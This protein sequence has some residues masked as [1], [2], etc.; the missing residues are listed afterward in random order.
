[1]INKSYNKIPVIDLFAGPGGLA[2]GFSSFRPE[3]GRPFKI[4]LSI[5]KDIH[6]YRTLELRSFFRQFPD[7]QV[8]N[9]YYSYLQNHI[10]RDHLFE[11]YPEEAEAAKKDAW[12][13][14]LGGQNVPDEVV[15]GRIEA[16]LGGAKNWILIGGPPCQAYSTVGRSRNKGN[17]NYKPEED[18]RHFLYRHYLR[19]IA[20]HQPAFFVMENVRGLLSSKVNGSRIF[21][22]LLEDLH[23]PSGSFENTKPDIHPCKYRLHSL[24]RPAFFPADSTQPDFSPSDFLIMS[25]NYGIPQAR[26]RL[27]LLGIRE[28]VWEVW[29][30]ILVPQEPVA[31]SQVLDDLPKLRS[32]LSREEDL[33]DTWEERVC[34]IIADPLFSKLYNKRENGVR[35]RIGTALSKLDCTKEYGRG[36]EFLFSNNV[37]RYMKDWFSDPKLN[38]ICNH[39]SKAHMTSDLHRYIFAACFASEHGRSPTLPDFPK[40]L[41]PE[42]KN[43]HRA[44]R[45][46]NF[47]DRFRVQLESKPSTTIMSHIAKDGHYYIHYDASQ[48]RSL[49]VREAA[50]LQ[51]FPDNYYF[52]GPRTQQYMQVGN[53]VPP[54]LSIQIAEIVYDLI[55]RMA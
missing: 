35:D 39:T 14:E 26:H 43:A 28:D 24:A 27:I 34:E 50:R 3:A 52:E 17:K 38:G 2:E 54:L 23:D 15:D 16:A 11:L 12:C 41:W 55:S 32:G 10:S 20:R 22:H 36:S 44:K 45:S 46:G 25:E 31:A 4:C 13:T 8:P 5:E 51:T 33:Q 29:P 18:N 19:I 21:N 6:A 42:H 9:E 40:A 30:D 7:D 47:S 48:C 49:T 53:A 37:C 1:M